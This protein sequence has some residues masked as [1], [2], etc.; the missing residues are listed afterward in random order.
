MKLRDT[1]YVADHRARVGVE[2]GALRIKTPDGDS[3]RIPLEGVERLVLLGR[4][5][6]SNTVMAECTR[7][8]IRISAV[9]R[10]GRIRFVVGGPVGGNVLLRVAQVRAADSS[11]WGLAMARTIVSA[12]IHNSRQVLLR[13]SWDLA[14]SDA[15]FV[16]GLAERLTARIGAL[17][18][19]S[20]LDTVRGVEGDAARLHFKALGYVLS[21]RR[22]DVGLDHRNRRPPRDPVNAMLSFAYGLL[23]TE[24]I[25]AAETV[26]LDPQIGFLHGLRPG[27]PSLALDLIEEMRAP[28]ADRFVVGAIARRQIRLEHLEQIPG[29][30]WR[31]TDDGRRMFLDLWEQFRAR[32][33]GHPYLDRDV[34][35]WALLNT[36]AMLLA[37][38]LRG[39]LDA[40]P[41]WAA[42]G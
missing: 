25:G 19:A 9:S 35:I 27:R 37:R 24:A 28:L 15:T 10:S 14:G 23:T 20:D 6:I 34:P 22:L 18:A 21:A 2:K 29:G 5:S 3:A 36:Q 13:W 42:R 30:A 11:T 39:D 1:V 16:S 8:A 32:S 12:K 40:Y 7:R 31:L 4:S 26:G 38:H 41:A 33:V 17:G